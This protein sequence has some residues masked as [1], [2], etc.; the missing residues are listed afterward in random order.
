MSRFDNPE[1]IE[2][3]KTI[4]GLDD[5]AISRVAFLCWCEQVERDQSKQRGK[6]TVIEG[7]KL[8]EPAGNRSPE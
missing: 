3:E 8:D 7:G 5:A 6:F 2:L 1:W 4:K